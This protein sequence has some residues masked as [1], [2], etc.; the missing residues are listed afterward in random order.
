V[1]AP[2]RGTRPRNRRQLIIAAA[3]ELFVARG[4]PHVG[5]SDIAAAVA[6]GPSA[7][8]R[9]V[10]GKQEL[11]F[12]AVLSAMTSVRLDSFGAIA[13]WVL[14][15][16]G[17]GVLWQRESRHLEPAARAKLRD[18]L[19]GLQRQAMALVPCPVDDTAWAERDLL[20]WAAMGALM[21]VSF[22][23]VRLP[24][25][26]FRALLV[27]IAEDVAATRLPVS[28]PGRPA[29][30]ELLP[31]STRGTILTA[32]VRLFAARGY[33]SVGIEEIGAAAGIAGPSIY[34]H[35]ASKVDV[36]VA[37]MSLGAAE[38]RARMA[39]A[40]G[41]GAVLRSYVDYALAHSDV[42]DVLIAE[43]DHLP[44][45]HRGPLRAAQRAYVAEW[46][47]LMA[48]VH[49]RLPA[50]HARVRI[51]AALT[52]TTDLARTHHLSAR[53]GI[54]AEIQAVGERILRL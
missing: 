46:S 21:S 3:A 8:Y 28:P 1:P 12:E 51:Q 2:P 47:R 20:G 38:L 50:A 49:P 35:F 48:R 31:P 27:T 6:I 45:E 4:Y 14:T 36:L 10:S 23:R 24:A 40:S 43:L 15:H 52:V 13:D 34:H 18:E 41:L 17:L 30:S 29:R 39:T 16:R 33:H 11:L 37:G 53:P 44:D 32:A 54:A 26:E 42:L 19:V 25:A 22:H 5:M 9:H 7:L